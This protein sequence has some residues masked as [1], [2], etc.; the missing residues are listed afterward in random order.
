MQG[1]PS[2]TVWFNILSI[3]V[4]AAGALGFGDFTP[5]P[6]VIE[7]GAILVSIINLWLRLRPLTPEQESRGVR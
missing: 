6:Q 5:S 3:V 4:M 2:L 1:T 7:I